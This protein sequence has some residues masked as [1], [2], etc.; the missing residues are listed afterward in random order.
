MALATVQNCKDYL[1]IEVT[2]EDGL[3]T[4]LLARAIAAIERELGYALTSV[5]RTHVDYTEK[6]NHGQQPVLALPGPFKTSGPAPVVTDVGGSTVDSANYTLDPL[7]MKIRA[8]F[9][10]DFLNRPYTIVATI[11]LSEHPEYAPRL[12]SIVNLAIIDL[13]AYLYQ[14]RTPGVS[15]FAEEGGGATTYEGVGVPTRIP[16]GVLE[17]LDLLPGRQGGMVLA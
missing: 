1:K 17:W 15:S 14:N 2:D 12:E 11:G 13:V 9:G 8:I 16:G 4:A 7:G 3:I 10:V 6:D 5:Q